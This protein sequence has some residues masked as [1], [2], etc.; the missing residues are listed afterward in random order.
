MRTYNEK[1]RVKKCRYSQKLDDRFVS[2]KLIHQNNLRV[3][4]W[5]N[6]ADLLRTRYEKIF[7]LG[8]LFAIELVA[9]K[10]ECSITDVR[11]MIFCF[12]D[13]TLLPPTLHLVNE[14]PEVVIDYW[15]V[16]LG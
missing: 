14:R 5:R 8:K 10:L 2:E 11:N 4:L 1:F 13:G 9:K 6:S 12:N 15:R 16:S 7:K 3:R